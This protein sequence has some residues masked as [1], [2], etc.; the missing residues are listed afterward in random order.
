M[1]ALTTSNLMT[2]LNLAAEGAGAAFVSDAIFSG[3][4]LS[5]ALRFFTVGDPPARWETG[6]AFRP[7]VPASTP[8]RLLVRAIQ[9]V[10]P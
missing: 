5:P 9:D 6:F 8:T 10:F 4:P 3:G 7:G 2:A 1:A